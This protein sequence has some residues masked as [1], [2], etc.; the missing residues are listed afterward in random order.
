MKGT[1]S[2]YFAGKTMRLP[3]GN[4][5][6]FS[7]KSCSGSLIRW[8]QHGN[9]LHGHS[10]PPAITKVLSLNIFWY[11]LLGKK[12]Q[13]PLIFLPTNPFPGVFLGCEVQVPGSRAVS[14]QWCLL[15]CRNCPKT[16]LGGKPPGSGEGTT[17]R[18]ESQRKAGM[19][20]RTRLTKKKEKRNR[21]QEQLWRGYVLPR[22]CVTTLGQLSTNAEWPGSVP[23][24]LEI[25]AAV[26]Q[27]LLFLVAHCWKKRAKGFTGTPSHIHNE[28]GPGTP[29]F[30][31]PVP[32]SRCSSK[33]AVPVSRGESLIQCKLLLWLLQKAFL[34]R[35]S[36]FCEKGDKRNREGGREGSDEPGPRRN[37][38]T[39]KLGAEHG[40]L[41]VRC[42][43]GT[44]RN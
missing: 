1:I 19:L 39:C 4:R 20:T 28:P 29:A 31:R 9:Q 17:G 14:R 33:K 22:A 10:C 21:G 8:Q 23:S 35:G 18:K 38:E 16:W 32:C 26:A 41:L 15:P 6:C 40:L 11:L 25:S 27:P 13:S 36:C 12:N 24:W 43:A 2:L 37:P 7:E 44:S 5:A 42:Q 30:C 34:F 3:T